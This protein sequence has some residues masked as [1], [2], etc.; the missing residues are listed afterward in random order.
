MNNSDLLHKINSIIKPIAEL[1]TFL[2]TTKLGLIILL[3]LFILWFYFRIYNKLRERKLLNETA[4]GEH[5][6]SF[7]EFFSIIF[8]ELSNFVAYL[9]ANFTTLLIVLVVMLTI[10][11]LSSTFSSVETFLN[12]QKQIENLNIALKNL[13]TDYKV[14]K[15]EV[16]NVDKIHDSIEINVKFFDYAKNDY[17]PKEQTLKLPGHNIYFLMLLVNFK[18]SL[19]ENGEQIN[20]AL[21]YEIFTEKQSQEQGVRLDYA[22]SLGVPFIFH[23]DSSEVYGLGYKQYNSAI[24]EIAGF[25]TD[26]QK[27]KKAGVVSYYDA[28]PHYVRTLRKGQ[29]FE[30]WVEQ[31]RGLVIKQDEW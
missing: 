11:G 22:D 27:A 15:V 16:L 17:T 25:L 23:R 2:F 18:Y 24:T 5:G 9:I 19:I 14:A 7:K 31:T 8:E 26:K 29:T 3:S 12:K 1:I 13:E 6:L 10:V 28:A 30:I 20:I 21:P 4:S